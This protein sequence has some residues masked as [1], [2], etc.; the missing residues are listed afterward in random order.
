MNIDIRT[1]ICYARQDLNLRL[2]YRET[3]QNNATFAT[4]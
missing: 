2:G 4:Q 1:R 3:S